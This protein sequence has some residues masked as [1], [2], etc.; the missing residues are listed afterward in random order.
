[1]LI[2]EDDGSSRSFKFGAHNW[3]LSGKKESR[4]LVD[5][6]DSFSRNSDSSL[7]EQ[8]TTQR[9]DA[10]SLRANKGD[11]PVLYQKRENDTVSGVLGTK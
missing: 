10:L 4:L 7:T 6:A 8:K 1:M 2:S 11:G 9:S 5:S 3:P